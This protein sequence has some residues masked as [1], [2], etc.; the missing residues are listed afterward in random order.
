[1]THSKKYILYNLHPDP[2]QTCIYVF[3]QLKQAFHEVLVNLC[4]TSAYLLMFS[5]F[6][7]YFTEEKERKEEENEGIDQLK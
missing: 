4:A 7:F 2:V 1:M 6:L 5:I 3:I